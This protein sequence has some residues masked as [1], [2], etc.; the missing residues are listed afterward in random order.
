M[1][2]PSK[3]VAGPW[4]RSLL[5]MLLYAAGTAA[6]GTRTQHRGPQGGHIPHA[7]I[8]S[9]ASVQRMQGPALEQSNSVSAVQRNGS[10]SRC[11]P[12]GPQ[13]LDTVMKSFDKDGNGSVNYFEFCKSLF[14]SLGVN[15][16]GR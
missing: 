11:L 4:L 2:R 5:P 1:A 15:P 14:P 12:F 16:S 10:A 7:H 9:L 3:Q 6:M 13:V 8:R